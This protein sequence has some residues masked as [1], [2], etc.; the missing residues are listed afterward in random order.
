[1]FGIEHR[2]TIVVLGGKH[3]VTHAC[4]LSRL[5]PLLGIEVDRVEIF[6]QTPV[7]FFEIIIGNGA[8]AIY[9]VFGA[10]L[11]GL[12]NAGHCIQTPMDDHAEFDILPLVQLLFYQWVFRPFVRSGLR[13]HIL[14]R[15]QQRALQ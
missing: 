10:K 7:P 8:V 3:Q 4:R 5:C 6:F 2:K 13:M 11:P 9:P 1:L 15:L 12:Y 14:L